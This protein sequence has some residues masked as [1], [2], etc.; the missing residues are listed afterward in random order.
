MVAEATKEDLAAVAAELR[1]LLESN[2]KGIAENGRQL[3][4][5]KRELA[6]LN[7]ATGG[8]E[9]GNRGK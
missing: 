4:H 9:R 5:I 7:V 3:G 8:N 2:G 1:A 6:G